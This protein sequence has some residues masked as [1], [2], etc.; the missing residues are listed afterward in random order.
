MRED[1]RSPGKRETANGAGRGLQWTAG[2]KEPIRTGTLD[3]VERMGGPGVGEEAGRIDQGEDRLAF[4]G[5]R[6]KKKVNGTDRKK[7]LSRARRREA[8]SRGEIKQPQ[9]KRPEEKKGR[10]VARREGKR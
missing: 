5:A 10:L 7:G 4:L 3:G 8:T 1:R 6:G 9:E 2:G